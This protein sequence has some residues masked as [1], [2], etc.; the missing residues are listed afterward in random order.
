M[1]EYEACIL[2]IGMSVNMNI[3]ELLVI[4][5]CDL[6]IHQVQREWSTKNVKILM[7]MHYVKELCKKFTNIK[8]KHIPRIQN[9]FAN[10]LVTLSSMIQHHDKNYID[11]I[12]I[13]IKDQH[14]YCLYVNEEPHGKPWY[15]DI[16]KFLANQEY[17]ENTTNGQ[18]R[19]LRRLANHFFLNGEVLYRRTPDLGLLRCVDVAEATRLLEETHTGVCGPHM[20]GFTLA[21]KSLRAEYFWMTMESDNIY[22]VQKCH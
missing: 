3:K 22:Y 19:A 1:A 12:E 20:N 16:K 21:K 6:L 5:D 14:A 7:Y 13:E 4:G 9:E 17:P 15:H 18:N 8:F 11:P 10:A 2:R